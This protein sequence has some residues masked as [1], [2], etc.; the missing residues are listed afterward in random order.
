MKLQKFL[1]IG[2]L[3][4]AFSGLS[5]GASQ[6]LSCA[7]GFEPKDGGMV[8]CV[9]IDSSA[10]TAIDGEDV[11]P[12]VAAYSEDTPTVDENNCWTSTD[13]DGNE[14]YVCSRSAVPLPGSDFQD[15]S[16][17]DCTTTVDETGAELTACPDVMYSSGQV[18][19]N[20]VPI[21]EK[22]D[23]DLISAN[24][25]AGPK[26]QDSSNLLAALGVLV[27]AAGAFGIGLS[28]QRAVKK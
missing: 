10:Y 12:E 26:A 24:G 15:G 8:E 7:E 25:L 13:A 20:G 23:I 2:M 3:A 19:E 28:K 1:I 27:A 17:V 22:R 9:S 16:G 18:D 21:M 11:Y 14:S 4:A 5:V 6:A